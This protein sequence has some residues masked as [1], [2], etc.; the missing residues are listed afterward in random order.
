MAPSSYLSI[1]FVA[2]KFVLLKLFSLNL[3]VI[4]MDVRYLNTP[5]R[6]K[7][8]L[9]LSCAILLLGN[10]TKLKA[11]CYGTVNYDNSVGFNGSDT[12]SIM[13]SYCKELIMISYD[14]WS[15]PGAGPVTVDGNPATHIA[16]GFDKNNSGIAET[17]AYIAPAAGRHKIVCT[18]TNYSYPPYGLNFAADFYV[19]GSGNP[20]TIASLTNIT[21]A[22]ITCTT[23]GT[24]TSSLTT[25]IPNSM[26]Y[27]NWE[28]NNGQFGPFTDNW[29]GAT[30]MGQLHEG[31]GIDASHAY[32]PAP[33]PAAYTFTVTNNALPNN[34]CGGLVLVLVA[35][36]PPLCGGG[37]NLDATVTKVNPT[38]GLCNGSMHVSAYGGASPYTY[39][40]SPN[41]SN[42]SD[43]SNLCAGIYTITVMDASCH[44]TTIIDTLPQTVKPLK[45]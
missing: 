44:D 32:E 7:K 29:T 15:Q 22:T 10:V 18:E 5:L 31:N 24:I 45:P 40:W 14:G 23:G 12:C 39:S 1:Y 28:N 43:A 16:T 21:I 3:L 41:V 9:L 11:Q 30:K 27:C 25:T 34:G 4:Q 6:M 37:G 36:P 33:T 8:I 2:L 35:I 19:T 38:C 20:L 26:I 17:Y 42:D 13:T